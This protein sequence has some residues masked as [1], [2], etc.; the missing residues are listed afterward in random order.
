LYSYYS[1]NVMMGTENLNY[2][3]YELFAFFMNHDC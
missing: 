1:S 3:L 2:W